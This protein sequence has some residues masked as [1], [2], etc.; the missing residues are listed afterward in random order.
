VVVPPSAV[1]A[2]AQNIALQQQ[3]Q[4]RAVSSA[5][6]AL[7]QQMI[8]N[9]QGQIVTIGAAQVCLA[10][11]QNFSGKCRPVLFRV[12]LRELVKLCI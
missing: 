7:S 3:Q 11:C 6:L 12:W 10:G 5:S 2:A 1:T 4:Q 8:T 9:T